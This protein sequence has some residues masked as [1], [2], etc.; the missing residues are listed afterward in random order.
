MAATPR[1]ARPSPAPPLLRL[2]AG[3]APAA[4]LLALVALA[5]AACYATL[6]LSP[7]RLDYHAPDR[8]FNLA[9]SLGEGFSG[10]VR[11]VL[12]MALLFAL[13]LAAIALARR[14]G[15]ARAL[16]AIG[17][18]VLVAL[19]LLAAHPFYSFDVFHYIAS[20]RVLY[21]HGHN[22]LVVPPVAVSGDPLTHL[23]DWSSIPSPYG[24]VWNLIAAVPH[25]ATRGSDSA[26][27]NLLAFKFLSV[28]F[29]LWAAWLA[30]SIAEWLRPGSRAVAVVLFAWN[31]LVVLHTAGDAH[32]DSV[33]VCLMLLAAY[34]AVRGWVVRAGV[35]LALSAL[36]KFASLLLLPLLVAWLLRSERPHRRREATV[37]TLVVPLIAF[38]AYLPF[39]EGR[40][41][42]R[43]TMEEGSYLTTSFA[44][45][46]APALES[47]MSRHAAEVAL[48]FGA[49]LLF[50]PVYA[51]V[52]KRMNATP[53][54]F[55]SSG[56]TS[57]LLY[58]L[59]AAA[60]FMPW[61]VL[62]PLALAAAMPYNGRAVP[63][64]VALSFG[65]LLLPVSTNY[66]SG[67]SDQGDAWPPMHIVAVLLV[68]TGVAL[69]AAWPRLRVGASLIVG[70]K[71]AGGDSGGE[72]M[73]YSRSDGNGREATP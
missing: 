53:S 57:Y 18:G 69:V 3:D 4:L 44:A 2:A 22:P 14:P 62:W 16:V 17:G 47:A 27:T 28:A 70:K 24:P 30:G 31:P 51:V 41:T 56:A 45:A 10:L 6:V 23:P 37:V 35:A 13:Y 67:M 25:Y 11:F 40:E 46:F 36:V 65:A 29:A 52:L 68:W 12:T 26:T 21:E 66:L 58:L 55:L 71:G 33:M 60:W 19:P 54:S 7:L 61:Y 73:W 32:N 8:R 34:C 72:G 39:W 20:M 64:I 9:S 1:C 42:L 38:A 48:T 43:A 50:L 5:T 49:R 15:R 63:L 59:V